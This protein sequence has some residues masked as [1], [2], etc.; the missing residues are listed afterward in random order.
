MS[1]LKIDNITNV[2]GTG[3][4]DF[5][6]MPSVG[7]DL[8]VESG[9]NTDGEW[10]KWA[11]GTQLVRRRLNYTITTS[12]VGSI[13]YY[14]YVTSANWPMAFVGAVPETALT[15]ESSEVIS[16]TARETSLTAIGPRFTTAVAYT[17]RPVIAHAVA[18]GRWK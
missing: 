7:G 2:A 13:Y 18:I 3:A 10:I 14:N 4:P 16:A 8:V 9:S 6:A 5:L 17:D 15:A 1:T 12:A 11:D